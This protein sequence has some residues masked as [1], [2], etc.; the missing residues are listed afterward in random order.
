MKR[1]LVT[2]C[3][4]LKVVGPVRTF[5]HWR[6]NFVGAGTLFV[7]GQQLNQ[8]LPTPFVVLEV[9]LQSHKKIS[10]CEEEQEKKPQIFSNPAH[11]RWWDCAPTILTSG[12]W[13]VTDCIQV[14]STLVPPVCNWLTFIALSLLAKI[15]GERLIIHSPLRFFFF[16]SA[17]QIVQ[18]HSLCQDQSTV[19]QWAETTLAK[20]SLTSCLWAHFQIG[21]QSGIVSPPWLCWVKGVCVF[22]CNL[23][24]AP[25]AE[26]LGSFMCHCSNTGVERTPNKSQ[27]TKLT[28]EKKILPPLLPGFELTTFRSRVWRSYQPA[29][30]DPHSL[31]SKLK[32]SKSWLVTFSCSKKGAT[33]KNVMWW[34]LKKIFVHHSDG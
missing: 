26:W 10:I 12:P 34:I 2:E 3:T 5:S 6:Q 13:T 19:A 25:E 30:L 11:C 8:H 9:N 33:D 31:Y 24:P 27:H 32:T 22:R 16:W 1:G 14:A 29:I 23:P 17:D 18:F 7:A 21:F 4:V 28:L 15:L 20:C